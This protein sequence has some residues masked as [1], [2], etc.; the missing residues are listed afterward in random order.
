MTTQREY[1]PGSVA[2][3]K[4]GAVMAGK[5]GRERSRGGS[6]GVVSIWNVGVA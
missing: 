4:T 1:A 5:V 2:H 3:V 6:G